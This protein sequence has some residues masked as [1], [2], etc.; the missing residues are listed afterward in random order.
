MGTLL[1][2]KRTV[3]MPE[4]EPPLETG[5]EDDPVAAVGAMAAIAGF[6]RISWL[7]SVEF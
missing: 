3:G 5:V 4:P 7:Q 6:R 1:P 2:G